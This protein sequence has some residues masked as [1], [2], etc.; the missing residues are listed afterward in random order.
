ML[1][2]LIGNDIINSSIEELQ[3]KKLVALYFSKNSCKFCKEFN[4]I[5]KK[6]YHNINELH[7]DNLEIVFISSDPSNEEF[8]ECYKNHHWTALPYMYRNIKNN[9]IQKFNFKTVPQ[10]V[11]LSNDG[12]IIT[13]NG[14]R[15]F[16]EYQD[17]VVLF[18]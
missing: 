9:L 14:R 4:P 3:N 15:L 8:N 11:L 17:N 5:L 13:S 7:Q 2:D 6:I 16:E 12:N 10:L 18:L 1:N